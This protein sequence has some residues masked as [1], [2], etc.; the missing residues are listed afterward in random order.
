M[1]TVYQQLF[2][3]S[4]RKLHQ[5]RKGNP[6]ENASIVRLRKRELDAIVNRYTSTRVIRIYVYPCKRNLLARGICILPERS[7]KRAVVRHYDPRKSFD[8]RQM[9]Y[10][11]RILYT[12]KTARA[13]VRRRF[14]KGKIHELYTQCN[15]T[16]AVS[17]ELFE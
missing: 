13:S 14:R 16:Y 7:R 15:G 4:Q 6:R 8:R 1:Y 3:L 17:R 2:I 9:K 10:L 11:C 5:N 12:V